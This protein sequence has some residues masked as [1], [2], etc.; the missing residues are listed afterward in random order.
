MVTV[1]LKWSSKIL[2][3]CRHGSPLSWPRLWTTNDPWPASL[4]SFRCCVQS[5]M[6]QVSNGVCPL[7]PCIARVCMSKKFKFQNFILRQISNLCENL[8]QWQFPLR[9]LI[10]LITWW[11]IRHTGNFR[12][13]VQNFQFEFCA[14]V[15]CFPGQ[16]DI[17][18]FLHSTR[19]YQIWG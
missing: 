17:F 10:G 19:E 3:L 12:S 2:Y 7:A 16:L 4:R 15:L 1:H 14:C 6:F 11:G 8:H 9:Y 18:K 5:P 13:V